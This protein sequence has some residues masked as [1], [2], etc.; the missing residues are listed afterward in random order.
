MQSSF[1]VKKGDQVSVIAGR[2]KGKTG[3]IIRVDR[4]NARVYVK[5]LNMITRH[6]RPTA[7]SQGGIVKEEGSIHI[8]NV[9]HLDP[10]DNK[11]TR[12]GRRFLKDG[13]KVRIA[14]KSGETIDK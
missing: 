12:I 13:T 3:E 14:K 10:K 5:G 11:P 8:S 2:E 1:H 9:M 7:A 4:Q 6:K